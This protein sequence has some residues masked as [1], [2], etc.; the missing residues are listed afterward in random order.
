MSWLATGGVGGGLLALEGLADNEVGPVIP[1]VPVGFYGR[2]EILASGVSEI[3]P[4]INAA[5]DLIPKITTS[6]GLIPK[7]VDSSRGN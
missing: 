4:V 1:I 2:P 3:L 6:Q 7:I 5:Q